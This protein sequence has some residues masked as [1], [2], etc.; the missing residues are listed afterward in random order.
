MI[1]W[2]LPQ[3]YLLGYDQWIAPRWLRRLFAST[4]IHRAWLS[5]NLGVY[6]SEGKKFGKASQAM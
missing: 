3:T 1:N 2:L 6:I 4:E 5:G